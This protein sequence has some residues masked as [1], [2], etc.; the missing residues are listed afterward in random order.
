M[1]DTVSETMETISDTMTSGEQKIDLYGKEYQDCQQKAK[2]FEKSEI[3]A[4]Y[5][6]YMVLRM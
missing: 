4:H 3:G 5:N 6:K 1:K 2:D